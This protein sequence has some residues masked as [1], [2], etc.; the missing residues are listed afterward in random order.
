MSRRD[1]DILLEDILEAIRKVNRYTAGY[2]FKHFIADEKTIDA[3]VR[4]IEIVGEAVTKLS[5]PL[6]SSYTNVDWKRI[7]GMRNRIVHE[8]F[9]VD[10]SIVWA[11]VT[12][13]LPILEK[14]IENILAN[15]SQG[16]E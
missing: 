10:V 12:S 6:K 15:L 7:K 11:I 2:E 14:Q 5:D 1:D 9:G 3:V 13:H 16:K 4:N 8:Y